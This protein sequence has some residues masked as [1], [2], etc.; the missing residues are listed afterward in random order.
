MALLQPSRIR[1]LA[2]GKVKRP[3]L[4]DGIA[5]YAK[6]LPGLELMELKDLKGH[7]DLLE[8]MVHKDLKDLLDKTE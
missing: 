3:W 6:R 7:Q 4:A 5:F 8:L 1:V 2:V